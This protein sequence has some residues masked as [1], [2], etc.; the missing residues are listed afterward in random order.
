MA[1]T[2][3]YDDNTEQWVPAFVGAR[4]PSGVVVGPTPPTD[5]TVAWV[6]TSSESFQVDL[7]SLS[8]VQVEG[9][10]DGEFLIY[11][12]VTNLF[13][14]SPAFLD[15][16]ADV[17][18]GSGGAS[19]ND[20]LIFDGT[21]WVPSSDIAVNSIQMDTATAIEEPAFGQ[22]AWS[23]EDGTLNIGL[24]NSVILQTGQEVLFLVKNQTGVT[25]PNGIAVGFAGTLGSSGILL[26][27]PFIADGSQPSEYF[28]GV[29]TQSIADG[30]DGYVTHF[31]KVRGLNLSAFSD[32]DILYVSETVAGALRVGAPD[33]PNNII[34]VA[35]VVKS[36]NP[37]TLFIR[38][39]LGSNLFKDE[40]VGATEA[41]MF[42]G[43][44][45][46]WD[47]DAGVFVSQQPVAAISSLT[48]V[49]EG[50]GFEDG[51]ILVYD[52]AF[53]VW[54]PGKPAAG[55]KGG[56]NNE[57]FWENDVTITDSYS[58][59]AGKNAVTA[60]PVEI[61]DGVTVTV[62]AGSVWTVV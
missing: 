57:V 56:G 61:Q 21:F 26:A 29:T 25:I 30:E 20:L 38:P 35:A 37:G 18:E 19:T 39:T 36:G 22:V 17:D 47:D 34:Q 15:N 5:T 41:G 7:N 31:G 49:D 44:V 28:M 33:A 53:E 24:R 62:P 13:V 9:A 27:A 59:T 55:A 1:V 23:V 54:V 51:D 40:A 60:G 3:L 16:L 58:I 14:N 4:G 46:V 42:D 52:S 6:D 8:D 45:L 10:A 12:S 50:S 48:D 43:D 2:Y 32:G 11:D